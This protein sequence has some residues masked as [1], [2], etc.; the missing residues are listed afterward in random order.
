MATP[1]FY[2]EDFVVGTTV[3]VGSYRITEEEI[4]A[5][6]TQFDPQPFHVDKAAAAHSIFGGIVASGWHICCI[7]MRLLV[8]NVVTNSASLGSPGM[9]EVRWIKPVRG[10]DT[11]SMT[12]TILE[13]KPSTSK[14][15]RG[16]VWIEW[17]A[18]NQHGELVTTVKAMGMFLRRP[19]ST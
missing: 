3:A 4:I 1:K 2:F 16:V 15:D 19:S 9:D 10:G 11:L 13:V 18:T 6:A 12:T 5:F 8:D 17:R 14:A 7:M